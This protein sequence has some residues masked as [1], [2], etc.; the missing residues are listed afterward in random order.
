MKTQNT[1]KGKD[2]LLTTAESVDDE[3][4]ECCIHLSIV[5]KW[6]SCQVA[7]KQIY[8]LNQNVF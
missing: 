2:D 7:A 3:A 5:F 1:M 4:E 6:N 8:N